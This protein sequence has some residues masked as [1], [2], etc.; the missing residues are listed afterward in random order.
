MGRLH[1]SARARRWGPTHHVPALWPCGSWRPATAFA[2]AAGSRLRWT[3]RCGSGSAPVVVLLSPA[4]S[5]YANL[6]PR[7]TR[8]Q[9]TAPTSS[10][11]P[12]VA[13]LDFPPLV[14]PTGGP[15]GAWS[16]V[17]GSGRGRLVASASG[18][19]GDRSPGNGARFSNHAPQA[20]ASASPRPCTPVELPPPKRR[21]GSDVPNE[22][23]PSRSIAN[24]PLHSYQ[25]STSRPAS[26]VDGRLLPLRN[27]TDPE[28]GRDPS[29]ALLD[30]AR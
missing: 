17:E 12:R 6:T 15:G 19:D 20:R 7:W 1:V 4:H 11:R 27:A 9:A 26:P 21:R 18:R 16:G 2:A 28:T 13:F 24:H 29:R 10:S 5:I 8:S 23:P 14:I 3:W 22:R 25:N 30:V